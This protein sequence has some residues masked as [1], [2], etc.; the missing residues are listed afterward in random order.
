MALEAEG[1]VA[2]G[3]ATPTSE[4]TASA[5]LVS[6]LEVVSSSGPHYSFRILKPVAG[7]PHPLERTSTLLLS[8]LI[9]PEHGSSEGS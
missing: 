9:Y 2:T 5:P 4:V 1:L 7:E 6:V 8:L 3:L